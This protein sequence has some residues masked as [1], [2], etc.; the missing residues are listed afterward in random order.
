MALQTRPPPRTE[1]NTTSRPAGH[2]HSVR[3]AVRA[4]RDSRSRPTA[5]ARIR[6]R[7]STRPIGSTTTHDGDPGGLAHNRRVMI[8]A[9]TAPASDT[10]REVA[11]RLKLDLHPHN[12]DS[13][14]PASSHWQG[15]DRAEGRQAAHQFREGLLPWAAAPAGVGA[16]NPMPVRTTYVRDPARAGA[17]ARLT[18]LDQNKII[19]PPPPSPFSDGETRWASATRPASIRHAADHQ[20]KN[21]PLRHRCHA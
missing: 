1:R 6:G 15:C 10:Y 20:G 17:R 5:S 11:A 16:T 14:I 18:L 7:I 2:H 13:H 8:R 9:S 19:R 3:Q 4:D 12:L 21:G